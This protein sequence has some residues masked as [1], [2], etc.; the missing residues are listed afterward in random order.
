MNTCNGDETKFHRFVQNIVNKNFLDKTFH[1]IKPIQH[2]D[3]HQRDF[4]YIL[5][6]DI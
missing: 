1:D 2:K 3:R 4:D 5:K 6:K